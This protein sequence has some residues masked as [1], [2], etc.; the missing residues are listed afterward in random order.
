MGGIVGPIVSKVLSPALD[1]A[2]G[3]ALDANTQQSY[4]RPPLYGG[5]T[6]SA[7]GSYHLACNLTR[8]TPLDVVKDAWNALTS[9]F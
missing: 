5:G 6:Q 4:E 1:A 3:R 9:L 2:F 8:E 7:S